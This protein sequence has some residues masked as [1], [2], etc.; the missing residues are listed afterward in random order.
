M[1]RNI[2]ESWRLHRFG[3]HCHKCH[4]ILGLGSARRALQNALINE[5]VAGEAAWRVPVLGPSKALHPEGM[6]RFCSSSGLRRPKI[7][8]P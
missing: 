6:S 4:E 3:R 2:F 1:L 7:V 8:R 5:T